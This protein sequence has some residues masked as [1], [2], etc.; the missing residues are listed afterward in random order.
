[1]RRAAMVLV[2]A[3]GVLEAGCI[4]QITKVS[5]PRPMFDQ[6]RREAA[7]YAGRSGRAHEVNVLVYGKDD[8]QLV[9]V[10]V[11]LWLARKFE[12][13]VDWDDVDLDGEG[14]DRVRRALKHRLRMEDLEK[15]GAGTIVEV[16]EED[17]E[18]V[19]VWLK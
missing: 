10:S 2:A 3:L 17:G 7:G 13:H 15:L 11:P 19:L 9:R 1:M 16:E 12:G 6:A 4:V 5:D 8:Q 14:G 18:Q